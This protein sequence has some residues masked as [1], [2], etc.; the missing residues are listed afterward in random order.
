MAQYFTISSYTQGTNFFPQLY[1]KEVGLPQNVLMHYQAKLNTD[2]TYPNTAD[3]GQFFIVDS[4]QKTGI[5]AT[6]PYS[7]FTNPV[8]LYNSFSRGFLNTTGQSNED[9]ANP[10]T[11]I[12]GS[13]TFLP[14]NEVDTFQFEVQNGFQILRIYKTVQNTDTA[15]PTIDKY[16]LAYDNT[17]AS[18]VTIKSEAP[19]S[20]PPRYNIDWII[21]LTVTGKIPIGSQH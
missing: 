8:P 4:F 15:N 11:T 21:D 12:T 17:S 16:Y 13:C 6:Y 14:P 20:L 5:N 18:I 10:E 7:M 19:N 2:S 9:T 3:S 1:I